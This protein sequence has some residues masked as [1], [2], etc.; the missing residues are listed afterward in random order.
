VNKTSTVPGDTLAYILKYDNDGNAPTKVTPVLRQLL[1]KYVRYQA[2]SVNTTQM[3]TGET[4]TMVMFSAKSAATSFTNISSWADA[5]PDSVAGI[6]I[7]FGTNIAAQDTVGDGGLDVVGGVNGQIPDVD[8]GQ[9][10]FKVI[11]K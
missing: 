4:G 8:A 5:N 11:V 6:Q 7:T 10:T 3:H 9:I 2:L 1:P